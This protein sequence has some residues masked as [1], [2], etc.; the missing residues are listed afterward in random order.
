MCVEWLKANGHK[1]PQPAPPMPASSVAPQVSSDPPA[2]TPHDLFGERLANPKPSLKTKA[3]TPAAESPLA[4]S[5]GSA[6]PLPRMSAEDI[7][8]FKALGVEV[9]LTSE[10]VGDVWLVPAY[11]GQD[12]KEIS[13]EHAA[14]LRLVVDAF[15]GAKVTAFQ[16][17]RPDDRPDSKEPA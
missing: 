2:E 8:S 6:L 17:L 13:V 7:A 14:T 9:C 15:P 16:K 11:T 4:V 1:V 10:G 12:R 3:A 5:E